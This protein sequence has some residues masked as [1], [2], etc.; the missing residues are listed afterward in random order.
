[1]AMVEHHDAQGDPPFRRFRYDATGLRGK[2]LRL[3]TD[4]PTSDS[5]NPQ[6]ALIGVTDVIALDDTP[7]VFLDLR[8]HSLGDPARTGLVRF[9]QLAL[10]GD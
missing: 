8:V 4:M 3:L 2:R 7:G 1:M 5:G 6:D 10:Y 9:D